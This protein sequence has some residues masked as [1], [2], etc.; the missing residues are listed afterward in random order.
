MI[1]DVL[2]EVTTESL[3][4]LLMSGKNNK[5]PKETYLFTERVFPKRIIFLLLFIFSL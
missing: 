4:L 5:F 3:L 2:G 1:P